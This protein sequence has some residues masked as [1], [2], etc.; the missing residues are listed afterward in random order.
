MPSA[1]DREP[2]AEASRRSADAA[3]PHDPG[4]AIR[5]QAVHLIGG[6]LMEEETMSGCPVQPT[7]PFEELATPVARR[8]TILRLLEERFALR[9]AESSFAERLE[10]LDTPRTIRLLRQLL[11]EPEPPR[12]GSSPAA[13]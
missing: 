13:A 6:I 9:A 5:A 11:R 2:D 3:S 7:I 8:K 1:P 10:A 4:R 12:E